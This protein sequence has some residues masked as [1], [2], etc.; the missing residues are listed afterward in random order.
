MS[1]SG[2][3]Q[4]LV[5]RLCRATARTLPSGLRT[6][7][8][9]IGLHVPGEKGSEGEGETGAESAGGGVQPQ[10]RGGAGCGCARLELELRLRAGRIGGGRVS[11]LH[12]G[13]Y[14]L[15][16]V[17][18][19][20]V[21][22]AQR[23]DGVEAGG[24]GQLEQLPRVPLALAVGGDVAD[25]DGRL[26]ILVEHVVQLDGALLEE[27][28]VG[29]VGD[30]AR[31]REHAL[32]GREDD[33]Q[34]V[35]ALLEL[36]RAEGDEVDQEVALL[37]GAHRDLTGQLLGAAAQDFG[38]QA[39]ALAALCLGLLALLAQPALLAEELQLVG[40]VVLDAL[41]EGHGR[42]RDDEGVQAEVRVQPEQGAQVARGL[43]GAPQVEGGEPGQLVQLHQLILVE[44]APVHPGA[45]AV[46]DL[47]VLAV[48]EAGAQGG[49]LRVSALLSERGGRGPQDEP[50]RDEREPSSHSGSRL[51]CRRWGSPGRSCTTCRSVL[52]PGWEISTVTVCLK[53]AGPR[54]PRISSGLR[55][56]SR[57]VRTW[58]PTRT[59]AS[60]GSNSTDSGMDL[61]WARRWNCF[62][63]SGWTSMVSTTSSQK[64]QEMVMS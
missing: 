44:P 13:A 60:P 56:V 47:R 25:G 41:H 38:L 36:A 10:P 5:M 2:P 24:R 8:L 49:D 3:R 59:V 53:P 16:L 34:A 37:H 18:V 15:I 48:L 11:R 22:H 33:A 26:A 43:L 63:P 6:V 14:H 50:E 21:H 4:M 1:L 54:G 45:R 55:R 64:A 57:A 61:G 17:V 12:R 42:R 40:H 29:E 39:L 30:D 58:S 52:K 20:R 35:A 28:L 62:S 23:I 46:Q 9:A 19:Q 27:G 7:R 32:G 31:H 51:P